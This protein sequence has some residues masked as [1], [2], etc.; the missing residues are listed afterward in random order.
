V[1]VHVI[2]LTGG[3]ASGKTT[4]AR[5]L[6]QRGAAVVDADR[7][8]RDVVAPGQPAL[9]ELVARF[10]A[11]I[12]TPQGELDRKRLAAIVFGDRAAR[13]DLDRITHPRIAAASQRAIAE[14]ADAG[15]SVVFYE[16]ALLVENRAH[17][18]LAGLVVVAVAEQVQLARLTARDGLSL[19]DARARL[20]AQAPLA[21]KLAAA[22][23]VIR[24]DGALDDLG[25]EFER[26]VGDIER[27]FG[28]IRVVRPTRG[29]SSTASD[30]VHQ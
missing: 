29:R 21:D 5:M 30:G 25:A 3:I 4:V 1:S 11:A 12:L 20:T 2:G 27:R 18:S 8:A 26:V 23:W 28:S 17:T 19:D 15:A 7:L 14:W 22:T 13:A 24:N 16:A 6:E 10:G 9:A